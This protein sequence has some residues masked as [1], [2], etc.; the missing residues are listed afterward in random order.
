MNRI[1][2]VVIILFISGQVFGQ[3]E[4]SIDSVAGNIG[5]FVKVCAKVVSTYVTTGVKPVT[6]LNLGE[7]FPES[8]LR[9]VIFQTDLPNYSFI[10]SEH[11]RDKNICVTGMAALY[12]TN[13]QMIS[14]YPDQIEIQ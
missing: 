6:Y 8:K 2:T 14:K 9:I 1:L 11:Y 10:P 12:K 13:H 7:P 3:K 5:Q 4:I